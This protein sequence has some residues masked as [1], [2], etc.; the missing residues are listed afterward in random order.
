[1]CDV[2]YSRSAFPERCNSDQRCSAAYRRTD[3]ILSVN[4][5]RPRT[6]VTQ[7]RRTYQR[8]QDIAG[9]NVESANRAPRHACVVFIN[10]ILR[11]EKVL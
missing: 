1:M 4:R 2:D 8:V 10:F 5:R 7:V 3:R 11:P 9:H 6:F